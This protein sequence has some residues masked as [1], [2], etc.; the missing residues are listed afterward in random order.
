MDHRGS[1]LRTLRWVSGGE[2]A[3]DADM[4]VAVDGIPP[5]LLPLV[6]HFAL[7]GDGLDDP[8]RAQLRGAQREAAAG[9]L[10]R[11]P[12]VARLAAALRDHGIPSVFLKGV[13]LGEM[14]YPLPALRT[15][16]DVDLW[17]QPGDLSV[18]MDVLG[19]SGFGV[20]DAHKGRTL[21]HRG[22]PTTTLHPDFG[23][24][25]VLIEVH[26]LPHALS[27]LP[28]EVRDAMWLGAVPTGEDGVRSLAAPDLLFHL[29]LILARQHR[30]VGGLPYVVDIALT[31]RHAAPSMDWPSWT[32]RALDGNAR[33]SIWAP[34]TL[35]KDLLHAAVPETVLSRLGTDAGAALLAAAEEQVW[36]PRAR[37]P[38]GVEHALGG[39]FDHR[40]FVDRLL[41]SNWRASGLEGTRSTVRRIMLTALRVAVELG[42]KVKAY[43]GAIL[44]GRSDGATLRRSASGARA[45]GR[46]G[47][48]LKTMDVGDPNE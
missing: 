2:A 25:P 34:L 1:V 40:W 42:R 5:R 12:V 32:Q 10:V 27:G 35:A 9:W 48:L 29:C 8:V 18:A 36:A 14:V 4:T 11:K 31:L 47:R 6:A 16:S 46:V 20:P 15:M 28:A 41:G 24:R 21:Y 17:V 38:D 22:M 19:A 3:S 26:P 43:A 44:E 23:H 37:L 39:G 7:Q 33:G 13:A 30:F 45:R